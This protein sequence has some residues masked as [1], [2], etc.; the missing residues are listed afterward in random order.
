MLHNFDLQ[1]LL[2]G[3]NM[4]R[5]TNAETKNIEGYL[6]VQEISCALKNTKNSKTPGL[7]GF[8]AEFWNSLKQCVTKSINVSLNKGLM[9]LSLRQCVITCLPKNGKMCENIQNW[10]PLSML[11]VV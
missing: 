5:K 7:D 10:Q 8:P 1:I 11:S 6:T 9:S 3:Q 4:K 2:Q